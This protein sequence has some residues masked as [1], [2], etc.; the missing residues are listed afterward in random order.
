MGLSWIGISKLGSTFEIP[1]DISGVK[2]E[3]V[4]ITKAG[5]FVIT[6][7]STVEGTRCHRCGRHISKAHGHGRILTLRHLSILGRTTYIRIRPIRY[8]C[9][10]CAGKPTT[11]QRLPWYDPRSP[12]TKAYEKHVLFELV[13]STVADVSFR[14]GLGYE[15][16]MGIIDRHSGKVVDW[17]TIKPLGVVGIDEISLKK[18]HQDFVTIVSAR[19]GEQNTVL[20]VLEGRKKETIK[21]FLSSIPKE[22]RVTIEAVCTDMYDG[23]IN[24]AKEVFGKSVRIVT[25]R[26]HVAKLYRKGVD[27]LRKQ[28]LKR[29]KKELPE[30]DYKELKGAMWV[31]RKDKAE[32]RQQELNLL[33]CLFICSPLLKMA[34]EA[35]NELTAIFDAPVSQGE[36]IK[37]IKKWKKRIEKSDL[38]CFDSFLTTLDHRMPEISNY[39][40]G[41]FNSGFVEGLNNKIK[42]IKRRCYGILNVDHLFQRIHIDLWGYSLFA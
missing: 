16:V 37:R 38:T 24:A 20:A 1:L 29:L 25:D 10:Y 32:L 23:Y 15:A 34:Y 17:Q 41:R 3:K 9:G 4:E 8:Q 6:V 35:C 14:E 7:K 39:F 36:A 12:H 40:E 2:I 5:D 13:N 19:C 28:E 18:G 30:E 11:T 27:D 33:A 21:E 42:V 31:L 26:F 22:L